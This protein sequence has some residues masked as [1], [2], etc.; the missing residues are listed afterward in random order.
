MTTTGQNLSATILSGQTAVLKLAGIVAGVCQTPLTVKFPSNRSFIRMDQRPA[1]EQAFA[2]GLSSP[3]SGS[4]P[5]VPDGK[6]FMLIVGHT[7]LVGQAGPNEALS[8]RRSKAVLAVF[9]QDANAW[10]KIYTDE[11]WGEPELSEMVVALG[12][13]I[14]VEDYMGSARLRLDLFGNYLQALR[15]DWLAHEPTPVS[16]AMVT[17]PS[18]AILGCGLEHPLINK[19]ESLEENRRVEF[20]FF[21][22]P[23]ASFTNCAGYPGGKMNCGAFFTAVVELT[24]ECGGP[25]S[26]PFDL[27]LPNN[28][29]LRNQQ[30]DANGRYTHDN[31][32]PGNFVARIE[33]KGATKPLYWES[34][35]EKLTSSLDVLKAQV[36]RPIK[37]SGATLRL[38]G[39]DFQFF[40]NN[41]Y[42]LLEWAG[43]KMTT[44]VDSFFDI[45][46]ACGIRV[47]RTWGFNEQLSTPASAHTQTG[48]PRSAPS[49]NKP[50]IDALDEVITRAASRGI[51]LIIALADYNL[52][53][54][55]MCQYAQWAAGYTTTSPDKNPDYIVEE[56]FYSDNVTV[57]PPGFLG[58]AGKK[59]SEMYLDYVKHVITRFSDRP[60]IFAWELM[61]EPRVKDFWPT[62][63]PHGAPSTKVLEE[64]LRNWIAKAA[65]TIKQQFNPAPQLLSIGGSDFELLDFLFQSSDVRQHIDLVDAHL[66]PENFPLWGIAGAH[67]KLTKAR[68]LAR[69]LGKPFY[70]GEFGLKRD[71][72]TNRKLHYQDWADVLIDKASTARDSAGMLAWQL[73]PQNRPLFNDP[74][75]I[76]VT[77]PAIPGPLAVA[78]PATGSPLLRPS[79]W[80]DIEDF[81]NAQ[82]GMPV[83]APGHRTWKTC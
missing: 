27:R 70:L 63:K 22:T 79:D 23:V 11:S 8:L 39:K 40:G 16:P 29:T 75:E 48:P 62:P 20:F 15:P 38:A 77:A 37:L 30:T 80:L 47:V 12:S 66:Y 33:F 56:L 76:N 7:D 41:A 43:Y 73:L 74:F 52:S 51:Y 49:I 10:E 18:P 69:R 28:A 6:S 32:M 42:Y 17:I 82:L 31:V 44:D 46:K 50:G 55:G 71:Q 36:Q 2:Y 5:P 65:K 72:G 3:S 25:Y 57:S 45:M 68:D 83:S 58:I 78:L 9:T 1:L 64:H 60:N 81:L 34:K 26:G 67:D 4:G 54:G 53:Y 21:K 14:P 13:D 19:R 59:P 61:N 24:D 35:Q